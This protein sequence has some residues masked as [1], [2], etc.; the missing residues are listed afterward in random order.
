MR[1]PAGK[2]TR[3]GG[4]GARGRAQGHAS[5]EERLR[6]Q[7]RCRRWKR[8]RSARVSAARAPR[9]QCGAPGSGPGASSKEG[10]QRGARPA[11]WPGCAS[12]R[13]RRCSCRE[14]WV[15]SSA[16][17]AQRGPQ[18]HAAP[19]RGGCSRVDPARGPPAAWRE[20]KRGGGGGGS[21]AGRAQ[22]PSPRLRP[23]SAH[24]QPGREGGRAPGL[25]RA[26]AP[27][28]ARKRATPG[29]SARAGQR[30][31]RATTQAPPRTGASSRPRCTPTCASAQR[32]GSARVAWRHKSVAPAHL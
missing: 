7:R 10:Q 27:C 19:E 24:G 13:S 29:G 16:R 31:A 32:R 4:P 3:A 8:Q 15:P 26:P 22:G 17:A 18:Q 14:G 23:A 1:T 2:G 21:G 11:P 9:R 5:R 12:C 25:G 6:A 30:V 20:K 28:W